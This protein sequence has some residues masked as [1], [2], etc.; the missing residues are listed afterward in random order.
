MSE[1]DWKWFGYPGHFCAAQSCMFRMCTQVGDYLISTVGD[2]R[3]PHKEERQ[4]IGAGSDA[5]FETYV[6][7][8]GKPCEIEGC[9]C[10]LPAI[11]LHEIDGER[12]ATAGEATTKHYEYCRKYD[13]PAPPH[14]REG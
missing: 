3:P 9:G 6:F 13:R 7:K 14:G 11:D 1:S 2:Y 8:A 12:A 4:T 5:Y 10:G